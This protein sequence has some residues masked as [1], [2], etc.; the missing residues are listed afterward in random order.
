MSII[1]N[2]FYGKFTKMV[3][4]RYFNIFVEYHNKRNYKNV[5]DTY[6]DH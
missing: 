2:Q 5:S 1:N 4:F 6:N 3:V